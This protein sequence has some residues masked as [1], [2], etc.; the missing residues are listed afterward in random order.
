MSEL[1][2][3][4]HEIMT[5]GNSDLFMK[6]EDLPQYTLDSYD[7]LIEHF[8]LNAPQPI[9]IGTD[10]FTED[11]K[12]DFEK[13]VKEFAE[14]LDNILER[15]PRA[16]AALKALLSEKDEAPQSEWISVKDDLPE[17]EDLSNMS[18]CVIGYSEVD[19][20]QY[21]VSLWNGKFHH[22]ESGRIVHGG[23][24]HWKHLTTPPKQ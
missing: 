13:M 9:S 12:A 2:R 3:K 16:T 5:L 21:S 19:S 20:C 7:R 24:S 18:K 11:Q 6:F 10:D 15:P 4:M 1:H 14:E 17:I 22:F 8:K 23:I